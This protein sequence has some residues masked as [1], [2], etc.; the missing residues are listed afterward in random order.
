MVWTALDAIRAGFPRQ[1]GLHHASRGVGVHV[2]ASAPPVARKQ[3]HLQAGL[4]SSPLSFTFALPARMATGS[5]V[6]PSPSPALWSRFARGKF[7][8]VV[9]VPTWLNGAGQQPITSPSGAGT[10]S[11]AGKQGGPGQPDR[12]TGESPTSQ[13]RA[14]VLV[15]K[16]QEGSKGRRNRGV[17]LRAKVKLEAGEGGRDDCPA[18]SGSEVY[19]GRIQTR[20]KALGGCGQQTCDLATHGPGAPHGRGDKWHSR[21]AAAR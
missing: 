9:L 17:A 16:G 14:A 18:A 21:Y 5:T 2:A 20:K 8:R 12:R 7:P 1:G 3:R 6:R 15:G 10:G 4:R 19:L 11:E 13:P